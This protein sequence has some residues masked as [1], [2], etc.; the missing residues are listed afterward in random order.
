VSPYLL[1]APS[2]IPLHPPL[3]PPPLSPASIAPLAAA[4]TVP[5]ISWLSEPLSPACKAGKTLL[6]DAS[7]LSSMAVLYLPSFG[8]GERYKIEYVSQ[9]MVEVSDS[10]GGMKR[11]LSGF[12]L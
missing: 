8:W 3:P 4:S 7:K 9:E 5:V 11:G 6:L 10:W 12:I 1:Y 2:L